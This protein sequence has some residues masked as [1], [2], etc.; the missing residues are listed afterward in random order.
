MSND[1]EPSRTME[2]TTKD[3]IPS[4]VE[5]AGPLSHMDYDPLETLLHPQHSH[6]PYSGT[7]ETPEQSGEQALESHE[8]MELQAFSERKE[9]IMEKIK[10]RIPSSML[11][12]RLVIYHQT[13]P[14]GHDSHR[15]LFRPG[16]RAC[17]NCCNVGA[18]YPGATRTVAHRARQN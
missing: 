13:A 18:S 5:E 4:Q 1:S 2:A 9:W 6:S 17:L 14:R 8:V 15:A 3:P 12:C 10:V 11:S 7:Q 16:C